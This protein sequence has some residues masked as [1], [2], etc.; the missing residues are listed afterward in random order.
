[1]AENEAEVGVNRWV[2]IDHRH[3]AKAKLVEAAEQ[4]IGKKVIVVANLAPATIMGV[5]SQ[6]MVLAGHH[7]ALLDLPQIQHLPPGSVV[8]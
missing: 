8:S 2:T 6:R 4:L 7:E 5:E 3:G 1:M